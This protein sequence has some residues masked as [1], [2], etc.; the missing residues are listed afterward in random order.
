MRDRRHDG[1]IP[2]AP[3]TYLQSN[4]I[5][6]FD[7]VDRTGG[8]KPL[9]HFYERHRAIVEQI[10]HIER[11]AASEGI[12]RQK[13]ILGVIRRNRSQS[14]FQVRRCKRTNLQFRRGAPKERLM[15][16]FKNLVH[17]RI[18]GSAQYQM[19]SRFIL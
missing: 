13:I 16:I 11:D 6:S 10:R 1:L 2:V 4:Q 18:G 19:N 17:H 15:R 8:Q 12:E 5:A 3:L 14:R 7:L 9:N